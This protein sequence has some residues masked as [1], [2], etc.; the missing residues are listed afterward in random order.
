MRKRLPLFQII[1]VIVLAGVILMLSR[2]GKVIA[3]HEYV[4]SKYY[5][6]EALGEEEIEQYFSPKYERLESIELFIANVYPET[7]GKISLT[8][9]DEKGKEIFHKKYKA[10]SIPTGEFKEYKI[11]KK[12][13]S[14]RQY[15]I[16][17]SYEGDS[18][19]KPQLMISERSR[20]LVETETMYV[21]GTASDYNVAVT[22]HYSGRAN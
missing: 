1:A 20:N 6:F 13:E 21:E 16:G 18:E 19:E 9:Y 10:S 2:L 7:K 15:C 22:Y 17:L 5:R 4:V 11:N 8:I 14:G 3:T 12:V